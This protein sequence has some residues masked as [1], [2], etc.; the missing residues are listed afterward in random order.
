MENKKTVLSL[1]QPSGELTIG[2]YLGAIQNFIKLQDEYDCYIG[3]ADLHSI[4]V[5]QV[6]A[7]LRRRSREV[8]ATYMALGLDPEKVTLFIQSHNVDHLKLYWV[9]NSISYMGQLSRMTQFKE[10]SEKNEENKNAALFTYPTLMAADILVY[11]ADFVPVGQ[12]QKQH[13]E[14]TRDLAIRFNSRYSDTFKIPEPLISESTRKIMSLRN[15]EKKMSKSD[16]DKNASIF[17]QDDL[18][19]ARKKIMSAVTDSLANFDYNDEQAGLKNLIDIYCAFTG[20]EIVEVVEKYK[21]QGYGEFKKDLADVVVAKLEDFQTKFNEIM[22]DKEKL[23]EILARGAEKSRY[24][25]RRLMDKVYRKVGFLQ[26]D[27]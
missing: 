11:N 1:V 14:L 27:K 6:P 20:K 9:L 8:V 19:A 16:E 22:K 5:P 12:D 25:T 15:P 10:K 13:L 2:N 24:K 23:D 21:G 18:N 4:T 26:L 3:V 7:D 17:L